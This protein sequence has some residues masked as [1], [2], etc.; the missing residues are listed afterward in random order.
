M[1]V[2][3]AA[4]GGLFLLRQFADDGVGRQEE[5]GDGGASWALH[6]MVSSYF[7][8][9]SSGLCAGGTPL[10]SRTWHPQQPLHFGQGGARNAGV[11]LFGLPQE[12]GES[13]VLDCLLRFPG[14]PHRSSGLSPL[15]LAI[16]A[17]IAG[18]ISSPSWKAQTISGQPSRDNTL[19]EPP[20]DRFTRQPIRSSAAK[21]RLALWEPHWLMPPPRNAWRWLVFSRRARCDPPARAKPAPVP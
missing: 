19:C 21:T 16:R 2:A 9:R 6:A 11:A 13:G 3:I 14:E 17:S 18:P 4:G 15:L 1:P 5:A 10:C 20:L 7:I 8:G 12:A